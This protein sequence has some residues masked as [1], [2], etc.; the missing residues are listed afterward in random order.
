MSRKKIGLISAAAIFLVA[1]AANAASGPDD[2]RSPTATPSP[3]PATATPAPIA[4]PTVAPTSSPG[5][6]ATA[7]LGGPV[8]QVVDGDTIKVRLPAG[9]ETIRIIG[10]DTPE[11]V[12][13]NRP[14]AC[15]GKEASAFAKETLAGKMVTLEMDPTQDQRDRYDRLLAH[16]HVGG[17]LYAAEAI[18][19]GYGIHYVYERP[20]VH[21]A[22]LDAAETAARDAKL[23]IWASCDGRVDRSIATPKPVVTP[24]PIATP[25]AATPKPVATPKPAPRK[26]VPVP[27]KT[28]APKPPANCS[29]S[30][31]PCV[32]N[33]PY[34]LDC[35]DI[36]F[37]VTVIG[38]DVYRLD[39]DQDGVGCESY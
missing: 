28:P 9:V 24:K 36:G 20:S 23:G 16:V 32:P 4:T 14:A 30:Y 18:A 3:A 2:K 25:K 21:A 33:V 10:I 8:T 34:D 26:P 37:Q 22:E 15:F 1:T 39:R 7:A 11:T 27:V 29:P 5:A 19:K 35:P 31:K 12:D 6:T 17:T 38:P 13:P